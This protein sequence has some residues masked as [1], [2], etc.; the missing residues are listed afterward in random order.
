[1]ADQQLAV[2]LDDGPTERWGVW[3]AG[4]TEPM[5][6]LSAARTNLASIKPGLEERWRRWHKARAEGEFDVDL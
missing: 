5:D 4:F 6:S 1:M 2:S 3:M